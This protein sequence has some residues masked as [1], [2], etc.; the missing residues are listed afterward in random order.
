MGTYLYFDNSELWEHIQS[1]LWHL[2]F[3]I[4]GSFLEIGIL[5]KKINFEIATLF[6][7]SASIKVFEIPQTCLKKTKYFKFLT[8]FG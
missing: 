2:S 1:E 3:G 7:K 4:M 8:I 5:I 6:P